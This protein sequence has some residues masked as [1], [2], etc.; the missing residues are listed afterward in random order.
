MGPEAGTTLGDS[1]KANTALTKL[2]LETKKK[3]IK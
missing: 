3:K 2:N 1:L